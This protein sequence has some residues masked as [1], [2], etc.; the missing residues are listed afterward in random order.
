MIGVGRPVGAAGDGASSPP[1]TL[2]PTLKEGLPVF[3]SVKT[4]SPSRERVAGGAVGAAVASGDEE[5]S[6]GY[7]SPDS[8]PECAPLAAGG[9]P[10]R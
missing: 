2:C 6:S 9:G 3:C 10:P 7:G 4:W 1:S 8:Q 5:A